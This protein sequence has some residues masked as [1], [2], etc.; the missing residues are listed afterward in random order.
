MLVS[1]EEEKFLSDIEKAHKTR[2]KKSDH[3]TVSD[4]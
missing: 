3:I 4:K 2:I 1:P